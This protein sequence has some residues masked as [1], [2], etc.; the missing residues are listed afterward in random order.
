MIRNFK[1]EEHHVKKK[2]LEEHH[3][4]V[5]DDVITNHSQRLRM[6]KPRGQQ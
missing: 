5:S 1:L 4:L 3:E 6:Q 2:N